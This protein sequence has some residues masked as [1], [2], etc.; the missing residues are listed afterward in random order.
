MQCTGDSQTANVRKTS[1]GEHE[2]LQGLV[3][4]P[5]QHLFVVILR[6]QTK[7][8]GCC[9]SGWG[10]RGAGC[11]GR[12]EKR[13]L[14]GYCSHPARSLGESQG[15]PYTEAGTRLGAVKKFV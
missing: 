10:V 8:G 5:W 1:A 2:R 11:Y 7:P 14:L 12:E 6:I 3:Q 4:A 9:L 13:R 15:R